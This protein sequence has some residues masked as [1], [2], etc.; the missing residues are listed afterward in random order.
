MI[1]D[2]DGVKTPSDDNDAENHHGDPE[3]RVKNFT[4]H[5]DDWC[6]E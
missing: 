1:G 4:F 2:E 5:G 6:V 3:G